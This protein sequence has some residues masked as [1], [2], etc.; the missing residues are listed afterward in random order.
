MYVKTMQKG[1]VIT[2]HGIS[3]G[4]KKKKQPKRKQQLKKEEQQNKKN[5]CRDGQNELWGD[6]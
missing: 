1:N 3:Q 2:Y 4:Q 5:K 6:H